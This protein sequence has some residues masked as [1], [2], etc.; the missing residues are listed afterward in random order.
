MFNL[1]DSILDDSSLETSA[2]K[3]FIKKE[4]ELDQ[5]LQVLK[6]RNG[7]E[8]ATPIDMCSIS[9]QIFLAGIKRWFERILSI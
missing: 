1:C 7:I 2:K 3:K 8:V 4:E 5:T 6:T 9:S